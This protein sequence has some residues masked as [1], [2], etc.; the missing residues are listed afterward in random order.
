M[1]LDLPIDKLM[2][3]LEKIH[4][5]CEKI[6]EDTTKVQQE[7]KNLKMTNRESLVSYLKGRL[8]GLSKKYKS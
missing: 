5:L 7:L 4:E 2:E 6:K 3:Q 8:A 1:G